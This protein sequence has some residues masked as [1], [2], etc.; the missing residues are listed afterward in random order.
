V[1]ASFFGTSPEALARRSRRRDVVLP[2][3]LAMY[4]CR[5][6]TD[7]TLSS[8]AR[9]FGREHPAV[10]H[11]EKAIERAILERAPL[12]YKLEE[13]RARLDALAGRPRKPRE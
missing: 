9:A 13:L 5:R 4:L 7:A 3:Q 2:R 11:A 8:V 1:V 6:Y 12:R 10:S